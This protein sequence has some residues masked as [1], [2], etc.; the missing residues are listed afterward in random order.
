MISSLSRRTITS[1]SELWARTV[2]QSAFRN[3][4]I[5]LFVPCWA[6][7]YAVVVLELLAAV[8]FVY[9]LWKE[10][11]TDCSCKTRV[12]AT[13]INKSERVSGAGLNIIAAKEWEFI[14]LFDIIVGQTRPWEGDASSDEVPK[15]QRAR[16]KSYARSQRRRRQLS[17]TRWRHCLAWVRQVQGIHSKTCWRGGEAVLVL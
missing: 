10:W 12:V 8:R 2:W 11:D 1:T 15:D 3:P 13:T 4:L 14:Q 7:D 6:D 16:W 5:H 17:W 9:D